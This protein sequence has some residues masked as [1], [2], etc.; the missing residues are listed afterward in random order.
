MRK[1]I[2]RSD[3]DTN[4]NEMPVDYQEPSNRKKMEPTC[5]SLMLLQEK[6]TFMQA[7]N[8]IISIFAQVHS[9]TVVY[10]SSVISGFNYILF[11]F[12]PQD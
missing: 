2:V 6:R 7:Q 11:G 5:L 8:R 1:N 10:V 3:K 12:R 9:V 4:K